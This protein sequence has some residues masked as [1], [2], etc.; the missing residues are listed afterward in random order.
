MC[1]YVCV[2]GVCTRTATHVAPRPAC[3]V[4]SNKQDFIK[5]MMCEHVYV[6]VHV[7]VCMC[8]RA[9]CVHKDSYRNSHCMH[10]K[11]GNK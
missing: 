4:S 3:T 10:G 11:R 6:C 2:R 8:V 7:Y 9:W 1:V 5:S